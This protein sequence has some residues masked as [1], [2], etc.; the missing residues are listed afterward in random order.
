MKHS[1]A[2]P[3]AYVFLRIL[4]VLNWFFGACILAL[5]LFTF[6]SEPW[7]MKALGV[8]GMPDAVTVMW[9]MRGIAA[10]GVAAVPINYMILKRLLAMVDTVRAGDPFVIDNAYRLHAIGWL[11]VGLQLI[12][13]TIAVIGRA[14]ST[15][16]HPFDLD[17]GFSVNSWL[18]IILT[19]VLARVFAEGTLMRE[20]LEGTV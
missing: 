8:T 9:A 4:I 15:P 18:A 1:T 10:L 6:V 5:L 19:F 13:T 11:M 12:S 17:A 20:D 7:T 2:L 3:V 16:E 14:I